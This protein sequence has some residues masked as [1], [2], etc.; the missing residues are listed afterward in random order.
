[1][2]KRARAVLG[3]ALVGLWG[4]VVGLPFPPVLFAIFY[5]GGC[6]WF[7]PKTLCVFGL[8]LGALAG[9]RPRRWPWYVVVGAAYILAL[10]LAFTAIHAVYV[11]GDWVELARAPRLLVLYTLR[12]H[13]WE[14]AVMLPGAHAVS[15]WIDRRSRE[16][17]SE[18]RAAAAGPR[19]AADGTWEL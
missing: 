8:A 16:I 11:P 18:A 1:L 3:A 17:E 12:E 19:R 13:I 2:T 4:F 5:P 14:M 15:L 6:Y 7:P 9:L 10:H